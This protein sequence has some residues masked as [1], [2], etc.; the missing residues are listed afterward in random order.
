MKVTRKTFL[1]STVLH[2]G[3]FEMRPS[4]E[5]CGAVEQQDKNVVVLPVAG[6]FAKHDRPNY[7]I[8]GTPSHAVFVGSHTPYRLSFPGKIGDRALI[9]RFDEA[10]APD[11]LDANRKRQWRAAHGLLP[12][13]AMLL[14]NWLWKCANHK[15]IDTFEI[16][17]MSLDLLNMSL[18]MLVHGESQ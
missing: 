14:R 8:V 13:R 17:V 18:Q 6:L 12:A 11:M 2:V 9:L 1:D 7:Q 15:E 16:E 10:L 5:A 3:A 4:S